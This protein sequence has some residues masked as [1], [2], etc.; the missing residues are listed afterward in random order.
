MGA[1]TNGNMN[2]ALVS[3]DVLALALAIINNADNIKTLLA[4]Q[5]LLAS[6]FSPDS[7]DLPDTPE[8]A[9]LR[10]RLAASLDNLRRLVVSPRTTMRS[11]I[12][13]SNDLAAL[14]VA[15]G[16]DENLI[17]LGQYS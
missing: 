5:N 7:P 15:F 8:H 9:A 14:R 10:S 13:S 6:T 16:Q 2:I 17:G 4:S 11:L 3:T 1:I 12:G